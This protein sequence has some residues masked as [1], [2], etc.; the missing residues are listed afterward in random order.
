MKTVADLM[1][2]DVIWVS[3]TAPVKSAVMLMK[4]HGIGAL[5]VVDAD[6]AV[7]G[8]VNQEHLL[9]E[10]SDV[11]IA[12]VMQRDFPS[13]DPGATVQEAAELM[14]A[15]GASH[16]VV[17]DEGRLAGILARSDILPELGKSFDPLTGLPWSDS[18]R[19]WA[20]AA[21]KRGAEIAVIFFDLDGFGQF[22]KTHGHVVGDQVLREIAEVIRKGTD[23]ELDFVCRYGG[24]EF[25]IVS[26]RRADEARALALVIQER[27][28]STRIPGLTETVSATFGMSGGRRT[29]ERE[30]IH[31]AAT[32]DNL[33]TRASKDCTARKA[34]VSVGEAQ[35]A[36][37]EVARPTAAKPAR[38]RIRAINI[39][40]TGTQ[41]QV[42]VKLLSGKTEYTAERSAYAS[43]I[44]TVLRTIAEASAAAVSNALAEDHGFVVEEL[45]V[46]STES[47]DEIV[48]VVASYVTPGTVTKHVGSALVRRGDRHWAAAAATL[49][50]VNRI[51]EIAPQAEQ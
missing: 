30:D 46:Q 14:S 19:E 1:T 21:L 36:E 18:L 37:P 41:A 23:P 17:L 9:G 24:D 31:Y 15:R 27:I 13:I 35:P 26:L 50:A 12:E 43:D 5:P 25:A 29:R 20:T 45:Y 7:V 48:T 4:G 44:R 8:L 38:F 22:N 40:M 47:G 34:R 32:I 2:K 16:L 42:A 49:D 33:I 28:S 51:V 11:R 6:Q 3:P 10:P 39:S